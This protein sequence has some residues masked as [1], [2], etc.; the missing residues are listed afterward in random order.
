[1]KRP[2]V[3]I[4]PKENEIS[5]ED[6]EQE[7]ETNTTSQVTECKQIRET[8]SLGQKKWKVVDKTI[9]C[10]QKQYKANNLTADGR[11]YSL[12]NQQESLH[13]QMKS[14][15]QNVTSHEVNLSSLLTTYSQSC[16][17]SHL[18][19]KNS[20]GSDSSRAPKA[21]HLL[22]KQDKTNDNKFERASIVN[23][24][25]HQ[26]ID[27]FEVAEFIPKENGAAKLCEL[28]EQ[29]KNILLEYSDYIPEVHS[30]SS[31]C[32]GCGT[33]QNQLVSISSLE[34]KYT[35][36]HL[37]SASDLSKIFS[38]KKDNHSK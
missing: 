25:S 1:M 32:D 29:T 30:F 26:Q 7:S 11:L 24:E 17:F 31:V 5:F 4:E 9:L 14:H 3:E 28:C 12:L 2:I 10:Y 13:G 20:Y 21:F 38:T 33:E 34:K 23:K 8:N 37:L 6:E 16:D 22:N 19:K 36:N 35:S 18:V 27:D 15:L